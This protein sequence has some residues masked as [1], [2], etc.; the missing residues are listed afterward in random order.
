M[1]IFSLFFLFKLVFSHSWLHCVD[2][3]KNEPVKV[4]SINNKFCMSY[5]RNV[6]SNT[7]FGVDIGLDYIP[8]NNVAC[9]Y[10]SDSTTIYKNGNNYRLL[11]PAKNH[12]ASVCTNPFIPDTRLQLFMY[13]VSSLENVDPSFTTWTNPS[14]LYKDFKRNG[15]GFQNC[16]DFCKDTDKAPCF[17]DI[18]IQLKKGFY[19]ALW[20][21]EFNKG[22]FYTHCYDIEIIENTNIP[23]SSIPSTNSTACP[24]KEFD[25]CEGKNFKGQRCCKSGF[26]CK[27]ID[28]NTYKCVI[29]P[30]KT[31]TNKKYDQCGGLNFN[32]NPCCPIQTS[33]KQLNIYYSQ[34]LS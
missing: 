10:K 3:D 5:P 34:C 6:N 27:Y 25:I 2:Y 18:F 14:F 24:N 31:C 20:L 8:S 16:P 26:I 11:W 17:G 21:W 1:S 28:I 23:T 22:Q 30:S 13:P 33:C 12:Q 32:G 19:K 7:K 9:K 15:N 4:G 29:E